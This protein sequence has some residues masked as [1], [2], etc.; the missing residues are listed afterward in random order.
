[1]K[2]RTM[3]KDGDIIVN[4]NYSVITMASNDLKIL[5]FGKTYIF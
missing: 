1:M 3:P 5:N 2:T 4:D